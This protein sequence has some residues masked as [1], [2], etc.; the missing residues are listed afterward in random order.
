MNGEQQHFFQ[1]KSF[2]LDVE[3]RQLLRDGLA[4]PLTPKA[5]DVLVALVERGGHLVEKDELLRVVWADSFV[6]EANVARIVHTLR[7][8]LGE[9]ENGNK[10]IETVAKKG[11]RFVAE[12][13]ED[14]EQPTQKSTNG[15]HNSSI[16]AE[17]LPETIAAEK[18]SEAEFQIPPSAKVETVAPLANEQKHTARFVLIAVGCLSAVFLILLLSF[19]WQSAISIAPND[20]KSIAILPLKP[21]MTE[22]RDSIYELGVADSLI[23]KLSPVKGL[24]VRP[25][26]ATR[27][28]ADVA[29]D[30]IAAGR[31][32]KVDYVLASNYQIAA[33]RIRITSQLFNV[34]S[35]LVEEVFTEEQD[36]SNGFAVQDA[37]AANIG[38]KLLKKLNR[39]P[40]NLSAKRYAPNEEAYRLYLDGM[41]LT[42]KQNIK[43]VRKAAELFEQAVKLDPNYALGYAGLAYAHWTIS[44]SGNEDEEFP[45][46]M[47][48]VQRALALDE[49][50]A[51]A[52]S[53]LGQ[54]QHT[55]EW[56]HLEAEK[57]HRRAIELEP[58]SSFAH[59]TY[60][61]HLLDMGRFDEAIAEMKLAIDLDPNSS[62][63]Q[64]SL[65]TVLYFARR[66]DEAIVQLKRVVE[67]DA[68][69]LRTYYWLSRSFEQKGDYA[70][71]FEWFL[72]GETQDG[73]SAE[74]LNA[75]KTVYAESGWQGV[76]QRQLEMSKEKEKKGEVKSAAVARLSA[77]LGDTEQA[78]VYLE[79]SYQKRELLMIMLLIDPQLDSLR[80]DPRFDELV[81]RVGLK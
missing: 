60:G 66:Y 54:I 41:N 74:E 19:N 7:K 32:Q 62:W 16:V 75:W 34:Q 5:F 40:N 3:E 67:M 28:Y 39:E 58:N 18:L 6:E 29:Q 48:A 12:V 73:K 20:V 55:Y 14:R 4:V 49:N 30:A 21:L 46:A 13:D 45:K 76:L 68:N 69:H 24:I 52:H 47:N 23:L 1:F 35:G 43:E 53:N 37:V 33:G 61:F 81:K 15:N 26:S 42:D 38:Q 63:N 56:K 22:N 80:S 59:R 77:Q 50:L 17:K 72:R 57:S 9:D 70:Q 11:Y 36:K 27:Q 64:R 51:E 79:K 65:G 71:A 25:L 8:V 10:F 31:E 78:F 44:W 2:R